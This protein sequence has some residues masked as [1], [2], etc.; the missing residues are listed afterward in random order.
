MFYAKCPSNQIF[1]PVQ[2]FFSMGGHFN[3]V[4]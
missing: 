2:L 4:F 1:C 3:F